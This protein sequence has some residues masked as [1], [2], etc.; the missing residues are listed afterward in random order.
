MGDAQKVLELEGFIFLL[1]GSS[2]FESIDVRQQLRRGPFLF[3]TITI[4][5]HIA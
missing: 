2:L 4:A 5:R 1:M 3:S